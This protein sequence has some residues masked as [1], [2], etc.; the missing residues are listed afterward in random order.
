VGSAISVTASYTDGQGTAES[1]TSSATSAV[2]NVNDAPT[3]SV[4]I[5]G[6]AKQGET[7]TATNT[8]ADADGIGTITNQWK[9]A[10]TAI[11]GA[12]SD[13]YSL[14]QADVGSAISV[15]ASYTDGG[16]TAESV[17][18]SPTSTVKALSKSTSTSTSTSK[19]T[20]N[21]VP[22][23]GENGLLI[24]SDTADSLTN[25]RDVML[26]MMG[27]NDYIQINGGNSNFVNG[28]QGNDLLIVLN[29]QDSQ[30]LGGKDRDI[31]L[32][33]GGTDN[34]YHGQIGEDT[35]RVS[36]G[37]SEILGGDDNDTIEVLGA[38]FGTSVNGNRGNDFITGVVAGVTYRGGKD[39]DV[40]AVSQGDAWG[41]KGFDIF[42]GV[43]GDG[44]AVIQDYTVSEDKIDLSMVQGGSW[45]NVDNGLMFTDTSG[46]RI[47]L[48][49]GIKDTEQ[50][51][52][53]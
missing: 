31:F 20:S 5:S 51:S 38:A 45:T 53:V 28:N 40:L 15:T 1:V 10:G 33:R 46:E 44:Y 12:T 42:R 9:R 49:V 18:S 32:V 30:F 6:T 26:R 14:V 3:G 19:S 24:Y 47:M 27:G 21:D 13:S 8:L 43:S 22:R 4:T 16:G 25:Q 41:D 34:S 35:F 23:S 52:L 2:A 36:A 11:S 39:D 7:L 50:I 29:A 37:K 17:T 48:L